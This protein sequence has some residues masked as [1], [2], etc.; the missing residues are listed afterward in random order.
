MP[1]LLVPRL[2]TVRI[3][4]KAR[5]DLMEPVPGLGA[6]SDDSL[7]GWSGP[8]AG[9][10]L[11]TW[12]IQSLHTISLGREQLLVQLQVHLLVQLLAEFREQPLVQLRS[13]VVALLDC[14][15]RPHVR[16]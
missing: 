5:P 12:K 4:R 16:P 2:R 13:L 3:A 15:L 14:R 6:G 9:S 11:F 10:S 7:G 1:R 8:G